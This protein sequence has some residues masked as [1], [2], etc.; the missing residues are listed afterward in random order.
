MQN[1][2]KIKA[3]IENYIN[4]NNFHQAIMLDG[5]WGSGKTWFVKRL[6]E[7]FLD[8]QDKLCLYI[9]LN[10][11]KSVND[12]N[13]IL[14]S[15]YSIESATK[16][17]S[18]T[19]KWFGKNVNIK[20]KKSLRSVFQFTGNAIGFAK[21]LATIALSLKIN[22]S[23]SLSL[24]TDGM[25]LSKR[26]ISNVIIVVDD[27]ER[28]LV[29]TSE[30]LGYLNSFVEHDGVRMILVC[31]ERE[32]ASEKFY[33]DLPMKYVLAANTN[34]MIPNRDNSNKE[35]F[36]VKE[37]KMR[38][39]ELFPQQETFLS[40]KEKLIG[41]TIRYEADMESTYD[42]VVDKYS[43]V[44]KDYLKHYD[45]TKTAVL[46]VFDKCDSKNIRTLIF[47]IM[48]FDDIYKRVDSIGFASAK[49]VLDDE[50]KGPFCFKILLSLCARSI[51]IKN[52]GE[53]PAYGGSSL[54]SYSLPDKRYGNMFNDRSFNY[55][56]MWF[57]VID[58]LLQTGHV[59]DS[60]LKATY[61]KW[62]AEKIENETIK[63]QYEKNKKRSMVQLNNW[64]QLE[65]DELE[66]K[67]K[68]L[69]KEIASNAYH[70]NEYKSIIVMLLQVSD[71]MSGFAGIDN[72]DALSNKFSD[73]C[74]ELA[75]N[76]YIDCLVEAF[77][78]TDREFDIEQLDII[79][80]DEAFRKQYDEV[81]APLRKAEEKKHGD[82]AKHDVG[83]DL[84]KQ[85]W[86]DQYRS[87]CI[88]KR[89][90]FIQSGR[91]LGFYVYEDLIKRIKEANT[92]EIYDFRDAVSTI[93]RSVGMG[94]L[95]GDHAI[96]EKL[97]D[98][99]SDSNNML[100]IANDSRT[101]TMALV[102]L[103]NVLKRERL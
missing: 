1:Q 55:Q 59:D 44:S 91:F 77:E 101:K 96:I 79:T 98:D 3:I 4:K 52:K 26:K 99:L 23:I 25:K 18:I 32:L 11:V 81:I 9:S 35:G 60:M 67:L 2:E 29:D 58:V 19:A 103:L 27:I 22:D 97:C 57:K 75:I 78:K 61:D 8:S 53:L 17:T 56:V 30:L 49:K 42:S 47:A 88:D 84:L 24:K 92:N 69:K 50:N 31:N 46:D 82:M 71:S 34:I 36:S 14:Y 15:A 85:S 16:I 73:R 45:N 62:I 63:M 68:E 80:S 33:K 37:I 39:K 6:I 38:A 43:D 86:N 40:I 28:C 7:D 93:Y 70:P 65:D 20:T 90:D 13:T 48:F 5:D 100:E 74:K 76:D 66:E 51:Q 102:S 64:W 87:Y 21:H 54:F 89:N 12:I 94:Y 72:R 83:D 10:G 95:S 41:M